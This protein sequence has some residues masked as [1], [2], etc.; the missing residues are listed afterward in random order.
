MGVAFSVMFTW[1]Y[2]N[3]QGSLL[4]A[5]LFHTA[6]NTS[7]WIVPVVPFI[8]AG[9]HDTRAFVLLILLY[10]LVAIALIVIFGPKHLS[11]KAPVPEPIVA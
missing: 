2:N 3:T 4:L 9:A 7:D 5:V 11:R 8:A 10:V 6:S 1:L